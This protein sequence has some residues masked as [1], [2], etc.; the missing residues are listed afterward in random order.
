MRAAF[1][2]S[3]AI[4]HEDLVGAHYRGQSVRDN[5]RGSIK[6]QILERLLNQSFGRR[7]HTGGRFI[8]N[9][10]GRIFQ[11]GARNAKPL[12]LADA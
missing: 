3:A 9:Q 12:F 8:E 4:E 5:N 2:D 7:V 6:Y 11:Q 10:Y 1:N